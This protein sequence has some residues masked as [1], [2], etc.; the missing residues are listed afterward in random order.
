VC[1]GSDCT[2]QR[3][4]TSRKNEDLYTASCS[5]P[6]YSTAQKIANA[7]Q[8]IAASVLSPPNFG[9]NLSE[10]EL[11]RLEEVRGAR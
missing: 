5:K 4:V 3:C 10:I 1:V 2:Y 6:A 9:V 8:G 7:V 11:L